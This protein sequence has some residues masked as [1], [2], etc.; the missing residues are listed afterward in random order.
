MDPSN[1]LAERRRAQTEEPSKTNSGIPSPSHDP[2]F[3]PN[4]RNESPSGPPFP[5]A[6][7]ESPTVHPERSSPPV[8]GTMG[9]TNETIA[10]EVNTAD[11][12]ISK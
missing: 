8:H 7:Q 4:P 12:K 9:E 6:P 10:G 5:Q 11:A 3:A 1:E 2:A